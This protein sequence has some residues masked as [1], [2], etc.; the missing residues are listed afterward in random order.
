[1]P[2]SSP[3]SRWNTWRPITISLSATFWAVT[4][5]YVVLR[6]NLW[7]TWPAP[8]AALLACG[9]LW[10]L[11]ASHL[12]VIRQRPTSDL[13]VLGVVGA[14]QIG[15]LLL[16][17]IALALG[18]PTQVV[19]WLVL[20]VAAAAS[21]KRL[22]AT[23]IF[24]YAI[25]PALIATLRLILWE[26]WQTG[27][28]SGGYH[29]LGLQLTPWTLVMLGASGAWIAVSRFAPAPGGAL[30]IGFSAIALLLLMATPLHLQSDP[31]S[32]AGVWLAIGLG[33]ALY[34]SLRSEREPWRLVFAA[35]PASLATLA[36][37]GNAPMLGNAGAGLTLLGLHLTPWTGF[38]IAASVVWAALGVVALRFLPRVTLVGTVL[39]V[40]LL[41]M[42]SPAHPLS[43]RVSL[44]AFWMAIALLV[45]VLARSS[46]LALPA[47]FFFSLLPAALAA[48]TLL[49]A[50]PSLDAAALASISR[51]LGLHFAVWSWMMIAAGAAW[52][53]LALLSPRETDAR[54]APAMAIIA[55]V[56]V[57][58][59]GSDPG[60]TNLAAWCWW[61]VWG[62]A[63]GLARPK[64]SRL[65]L[66]FAAIV[67]AVLCSFSWIVFFVP[68]WTQQPAPPLLHP[69]LITGLLLTAQWA[70]G[71]MWLV[72]SAPPD[73]PH[74]RTAINTSVV[75]S[76]VALFACTSLEAARIV[77]RISEDPAARGAGVS[78][79]WGVF[80]A[81]LLV[82]GFWRRNS[83]LRW[84]GLIL[85]GVTSLKLVIIDLATVPMLWRTISFLALGLLMIAVPVAYARLGKRAGDQP[86]GDPPPSP[87][88]ASPPAQAPPSS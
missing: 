6:A 84:S 10:L 17:T 37:F 23:A 53:G 42:A 57:M 31:L 51:V 81:G 14:I 21:S 77:L 40:M 78:L 4:L 33:I 52:L 26:S 30:R 58:L 62:V 65:R 54:V 39:V 18:G 15:A 2:A 60:S 13:E 22:N 3:I 85:L 56:L 86:P 45:A 68:H 34:L 19:T 63:P 73:A 5:G 67:G 8:A 82:A 27:L 1:M 50:R 64:A 74:Y 80:A 71:A 46:K 59:A 28:H 70:L 88:D 87:D 49:S 43:E 55:M 41:L 83:P 32:I 11:T 75:A 48:G 66:H 36:I 61:F 79:W 72:R 16:V 9:A 7:P 12:D 25:I 29:V 47:V 24:Y 38:M 20:A 69:G 35:G 44:A 76:I